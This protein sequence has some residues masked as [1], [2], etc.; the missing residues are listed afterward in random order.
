MTCRNH[1]KTVVV[2]NSNRDYEKLKDCPGSCCE[3]GSKPGEAYCACGQLPRPSQDL[4]NRE[5][6]EP[7]SQPGSAEAKCTPGAFWCERVTLKGGRS[8]DAIFTCG[9]TGK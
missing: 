1:R 8:L 2:C 4:E 5:Y 3:Y 9:P 7:E 6:D